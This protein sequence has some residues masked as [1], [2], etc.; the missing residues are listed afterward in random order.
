MSFCLESRLP[1]HSHFLPVYNTLQHETATQVSRLAGL[2]TRV[3]AGLSLP[4]FALGF[5]FQLSRSS[6]IPRLACDFPCRGPCL[7][8]PVKLISHISLLLPSSP[9]TVM[10]GITPATGAAASTTASTEDPIIVNTKPQA[11][12]A[13]PKRPKPER[14]CC[15]NERGGPWPRYGPLTLPSHFR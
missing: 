13:T 14:K 12:K 2:P 15:F 11:K 5:R 3:I 9:S 8:H 7:A 10:A 6:F 1:E 4:T